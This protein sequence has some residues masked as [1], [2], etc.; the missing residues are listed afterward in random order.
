MSSSCFVWGET[1]GLCT[2]PAFLPPDIWETLLSRGLKRPHLPNSF[3][4]CLC[5]VPVEGRAVG[6]Q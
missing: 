3:V 2:G 6:K 5:C 4:L 1:C